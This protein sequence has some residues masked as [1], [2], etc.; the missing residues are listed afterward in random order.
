MSFRVSLRAIPTSVGAVALAVLTASAAGGA[1]TPVRSTSRTT[2]STWSPTGTTSALR[3]KRST[4][5]TSG[6]PVRA[7]GIPTLVH[8][9]VDYE[10][11]V[12]DSSR[13]RG[14]ATCVPGI[15]VVNIDNGF[16]AACLADRINKLAA[17]IR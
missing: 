6:S 11:V 4:A 15:G 5:S 14:L 12:T 16:G 7:A 10:P 1:L 2:G 13:R 17:K 3:R 8:V 9:G